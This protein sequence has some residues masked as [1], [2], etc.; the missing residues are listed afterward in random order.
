MTA[1]FRKYIPERGHPLF[2]TVDVSK[3]DVY[4]WVNFGL[5]DQMIADLWS[6]WQKLYADPYKGITTDGKLLPGLFQLR[7]ENGPTVAMVENACH[8]VGLTDEVG[9]SGLF[10]Y[11]VDGNEWRC[12]QNPEFC[13]HRNGIRLEE[14][15]DGIRAAVMQLIRASLSKRGREDVLAAMRTNQFL[16]HLVG[17]EKLMNENSYNFILFGEPSLTDPW[18]WSIWG[19]H[20]T[21]CVFVMGSQMVVSPVF[22]GCEPNTIDEGPHQG[23]EMFAVE[24]RLA[25]QLMALL[26]QS[27]RSSVVVYEELEDPK[28]PTGFPHPAD[29]RNLA[30]A[31]EDNK[32]IP[33]SGGRV[34]QWTKEAQDVLLDLIARFIDFL[35]EGPLAAKM[36]D[37]RNH[38]DDTWFMWMGGYGENDV[39]HFRILSPVLLCEFDHECGIWLT[40]RKPGRFH[41]HTVVRTPN[42]NDYG[43]ALLQLW[44]QGT[45]R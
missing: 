14:Q 27:Q 5:Q 19:H 36:A 37:V 45:I 26:T 41:V 11:P 12:W 42:G 40:N 7:T 9:V 32:I 10:R 23:T 38:I 15:S 28:M 29:G 20:L 21:F 18:G 39:F 44:K 3:H 30:G 33:P 13:F 6:G 43:K 8:L 34:C 31:Y 22:R 16:G 25:T 17:A 35:P 24:M 4:S 1:S 2:G